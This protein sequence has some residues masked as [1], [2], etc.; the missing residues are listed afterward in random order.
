[1]VQILRTLTLMILVVGEGDFW[2]KINDDSIEDVMENSPGFKHMIM[3]S[4]ELITLGRAGYP[5][6]IPRA[7]VDKLC[8]KMYPPFA[9]KDKPKPAAS[10]NRNRVGDLSQLNTVVLGVVIVAV[11]AYV[12]SASAP[13]EV[14]HAAAPA[15]WAINQLAQDPP[16]V[17]PTAPSFPG[18]GAVASSPAAAPAA[19]PVTASPKS[20]APVTPASP[21]KAESPSADQV[22]EQRRKRLERFDSSAE[23]S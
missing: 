21:S 23:Q 20:V 4:C 14:A 22:L 8:T 16:A 7:T 15:S 5:K 11:L 19:A 18:A 10:A 9:N 3:S 13:E 6:N 12:W 2:S 1:M 17:Q